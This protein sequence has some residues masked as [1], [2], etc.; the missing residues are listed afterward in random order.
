VDHLDSKNFV[1]FKK[2]RNGY[3]LPNLTR[4]AEE[5]VIEE[6]DPELRPD[7]QGYVRHYLGYADVML[8][9][10]EEEEQAERDMAAVDQAAIDQEMKEAAAVI[11]GKT[12][13]D[14]SSNVTEM[15]RPKPAETDSEAA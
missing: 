15:P 8:K 10:A 14:E 11:A 12:A 6:V 1:P 2:R 13:S 4:Q 3:H 9:K 5:Q 7:E